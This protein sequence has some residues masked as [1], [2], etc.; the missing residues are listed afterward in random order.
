VLQ[1]VKDHLAHQGID[2]SV[3]Q[4]ERGDCPDPDH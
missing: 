2:H 3:V 4:L 1:Q